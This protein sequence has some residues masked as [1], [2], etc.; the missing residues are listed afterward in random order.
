MRTFANSVDP[1]EMLQDAA[2]QPYMYLHYL[3]RNNTIFIENIQLYLE[4]MTGNPS[5][6]TKDHSKFTI[7]NFW[8]T[9]IN[10]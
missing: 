4:I 6:Y 10:I 9:P 3:P 2:F 5:S 1:D 8:E 7:P